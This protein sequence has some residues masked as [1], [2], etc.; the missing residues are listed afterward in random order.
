[1][2]RTRPSRPRVFPAAEPLE[3]RALP[4]FLF[5]V[6]YRVNSHPYEPAVADFNGDGRADVAVTLPLDNRLAVL[7]GDG[8]GAV[9]A[10]A[11]YTTGPGPEGLRA[12]DLNADGRPDLVTANDPLDGDTVS[13]LLNN[14]DGTFRPRRDFATGKGPLDVAVGDL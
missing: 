12:A 6:G 14:G 10:P 13:V 7:L 5:P 9:R 1:M 4:G 11:Y 3:A 2:S 8:T